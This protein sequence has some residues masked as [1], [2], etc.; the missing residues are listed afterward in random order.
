MWNIQ[1][2]FLL[3]CVYCLACTPTGVQWG[4]TA[5]AVLRCSN[6]K[7]RVQMFLFIWMCLKFLLVYTINLSVQSWRP[8]SKDG[9]YE[10]VTC[11][12]FDPKPET[13]IARSMIGL[14]VAIPDIIST[15]D[16]FLW[17]FYSVVLERS[18]LVTP[19][20][21]ISAGVGL[22]RSHM[23]PVN[24]GPL[25]WHIISCTPRQLQV[26]RPLVTWRLPVVFQQSIQ[27]PSISVIASD[28]FSQRHWRGL[29][30]FFVVPAL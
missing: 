23:K 14:V 2:Y 21:L 5:A 9:W 20:M 22:F 15:L 16:N 10:E 3:E 24:V 4:Q 26:S 12:H 11:C 18:S 25:V 17:R 8:L 28:C 27:S 30:C 29:W 13:M 6:V 7:I 19:P 1:K